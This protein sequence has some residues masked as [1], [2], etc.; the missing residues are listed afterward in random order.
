MIDVSG[1]LRYFCTIKNGTTPASGNIDYWNGNVKW[2]TP[3]DLGKLSGNTITLTKR[4]VTE[5]AVKETNLSVI[6]SGS[7][8]V[9]TRAPIG[10]M[11]INDSPM[12]FNQGCRGLIP[13]EKVDTSFLY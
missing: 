3:E 13:G 6:P 4:Q 9:S 7:I 10:H 12:A 1:A 2:A 5:L 11:A 8:V